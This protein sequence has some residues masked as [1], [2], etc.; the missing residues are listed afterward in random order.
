[1]KKSDLHAA[2]VINLA[3]IREKIA[4]KRRRDSRNVRLGIALAV[5]V[6]ALFW[7]PII[8][9]VAGLFN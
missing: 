6:C 9:F 2:T 4:A 1:M 7:G 8:A 3:E 5:F